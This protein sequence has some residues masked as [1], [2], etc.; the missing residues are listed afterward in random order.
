MVCLGDTAAAA[1]EGCRAA[2]LEAVKEAGL[3]V[4]IKALE[5]GDDL[6]LSTVA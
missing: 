2:F 1:A 4:A 5:D 3:G 6:P